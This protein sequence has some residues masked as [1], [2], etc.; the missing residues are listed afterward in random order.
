MQV[1]RIEDA[2]FVGPPELGEKLNEFVL[3]WDSVKAERLPQPYNHRFKEHQDALNRVRNE[4]WVKR[5]ALMQERYGKV[6]EDLCDFAM[7]Q[8]GVQRT[9]VHRYYFNPGA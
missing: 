2:Y 8:P 1:Y 9:R 3:L 7:Q 4:A 5:E 6:Y